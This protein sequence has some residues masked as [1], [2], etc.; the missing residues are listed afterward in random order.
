MRNPAALFNLELGS[1]TQQCRQLR[2]GM[3][4]A[5]GNLSQDRPRLLVDEDAATYAP[6]RVNGLRWFA[7]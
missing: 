2:M 3:R 5:P 6:L 7:D 4:A 1:Q